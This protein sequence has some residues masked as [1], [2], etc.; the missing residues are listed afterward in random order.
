MVGVQQSQAAPP[1]VELR[2]WRDTR[3]AASRGRLPQAALALTGLLAAL[4][5][6][7]FG[8]VGAGIGGAIGG[9]VYGAIVAARARSRFG[10]AQSREQASGPDRPS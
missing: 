5:Q 1:R 2:R 3:R 9:A 8:P 6:M 4:G 10:G 7:A